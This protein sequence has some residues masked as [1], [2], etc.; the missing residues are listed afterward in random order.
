[1]TNYIFINSHKKEYN[2]ELMH[3]IYKILKKKIQAK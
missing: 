3:K 2:P 1:M